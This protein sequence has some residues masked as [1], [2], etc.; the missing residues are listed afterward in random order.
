MFSLAGLTYIYTLQATTD[1]W[2]VG[3]DDYTGGPDRTKQ[4]DKDNTERKG[5][6]KPRRR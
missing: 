3:I 5:L 6:R 1:W 2:G 4:K